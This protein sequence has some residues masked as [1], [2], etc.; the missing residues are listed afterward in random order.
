MTANVFIPITTITTYIHVI[1]MLLPYY[2]CAVKVKCDQNYTS[3]HLAAGLS[4]LENNRQTSS[5][6]Q[7]L[8]CAFHHNHMATESYCCLT[9]AVLLNPPLMVMQSC[10]IFH[11]LSSFCEI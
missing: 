4:G 10:C 11:H 1:T 6:W 3:P 7:T 9:C 2:Y 5:S 8:Q